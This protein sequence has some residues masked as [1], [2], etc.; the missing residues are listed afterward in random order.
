MKKVLVLALVLGLVG[1]ANAAVTLSPD[2]PTINVGDT[3]TISVVADASGNYGGWLD[4]VDNGIGTFGDLMILPAAGPD[5]SK[6]FTFAPWWLFEAKSF[7]PDAPVLAG[8]H[9]TIDFTGNA[10]GTATL[11]LW[12]F[13]AAN[14]LATTTITVVPEPMTLGLLGLGGLFLR[15]RK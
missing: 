5:A 12:D 3:V 2:A 8:A 10:E 11:A 9:F 7:N 6:D 15:R 4:P 1:I 14:V 13:D